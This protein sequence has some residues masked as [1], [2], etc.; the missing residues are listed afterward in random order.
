MAKPKYIMCKYGISPRVPR[1]RPKTFQRPTY[2]PPHTGIFTQVN[3]PPP[4]PGFRFND[5]VNGVNDA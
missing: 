4:P 5:D 3:I 1:P 2:R